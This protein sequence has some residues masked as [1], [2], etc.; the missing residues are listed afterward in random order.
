MAGDT[1]A[2]LESEVA[3]VLATKN[4]RPFLGFLCDELFPPLVFWSRPSLEQETATMTTTVGRSSEAAS[5]P[6]ADN[7]TL[8]AADN[9]FINTLAVFLPCC[10]ETLRISEFRVK[11]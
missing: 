10:G 1:G 2:A 3:I 7:I 8:L 5:A 4:Q 6:C 9:C 11:K